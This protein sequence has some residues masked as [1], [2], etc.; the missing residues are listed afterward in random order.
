MLRI[1]TVIV[2]VALI[3]EP[4]IA[5]AGLH[6][7]QNDNC[8]SVTCRDLYEQCSSYNW[9][10]THPNICDTLAARASRNIVTPGCYKWVWTNNVSRVCSK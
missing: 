5:F 3:S 6:I 4:T 2:F 8:D 9:K 7:V 10:F 1:L